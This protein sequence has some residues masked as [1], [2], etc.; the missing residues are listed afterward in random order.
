MGNNPNHI[1]DHRCTVASHHTDELSP[2][3]DAQL[4]GGTQ[5]ENCGGPKPPVTKEAH[6]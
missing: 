5:C 2:C 3:C 1:C 6:K 4:I